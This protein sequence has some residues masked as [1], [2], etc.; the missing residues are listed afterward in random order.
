MPCCGRGRGR[1]WRGRRCVVGGGRRRRGGRRRGRRRRGRR[2]RRRGRLGCRS[3]GGRR[4][5]G[6]HGGLRAPRWS[7]VGGNVVVGGRAW[8]SSAG[9]E[10]RAG[11]RRLRRDRDLVAALSSLPPSA[12][13]ATRPIAQSAITAPAMMRAAVTSCVAAPGAPR[14]PDRVGGARRQHERDDRAD[15]REHDADDRPDQGGDRERLDL[16]LRRPN[17]RVPSPPPAAPV[18]SGSG[19]TG[20]APV[21]SGSHGGGPEADIGSHYRRARRAKRGTSAHASRASVGCRA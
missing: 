7:C 10:R 16:R 4:R 5:D 13:N 1:R 21:S 12:T 17:R 8:W 19:P 20:T 6:D 15:E 11:V 3:V 18:G 9:S 2:R 14:T